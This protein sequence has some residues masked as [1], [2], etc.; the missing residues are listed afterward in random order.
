MFLDGPVQYEHHESKQSLS[1]IAKKKSLEAP[2]RILLAGAEHLVS[3]RTFLSL[4]IITHIFNF[5]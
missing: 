1:L 2:A 4:K 3:L 5:T